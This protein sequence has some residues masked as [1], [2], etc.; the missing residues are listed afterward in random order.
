MKKNVFLI[1]LLGVSTTVIRPVQDETNIARVDQVEVPRNNREEQDG[2]NE[3]LMRAVSAN[4]SRAEIEALIHDGADVNHRAEDGTTPLHIATDIGN[5]PVIDALLQANA[6]I[7]QRDGNNE[8]ALHLATSRGNLNIV[9][10]LIRN[11]ADA[12]LAASDNAMPL[13]IAISALNLPLVDILIR[14]GAQVNAGIPTNEYGADSLLSY[15]NYLFE[16]EQDEAHHN[17][18]SYVE[19]AREIVRI[20]EAHG[21]R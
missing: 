13:Y 21:A 2:L 10:L 6:Q 7:N 16:A 20:L 4:D 19:V 5:L 12:N 18:L 11:G 14:S 3:N 9:Q 17:R 1:A 15:A 8:T